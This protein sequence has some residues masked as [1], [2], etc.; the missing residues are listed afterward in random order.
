ME[1][2]RLPRRRAVGLIALALFL[3]SSVLYRTTGWAQSEGEYPVVDVDLTEPDVLIRT[4]SLSSLFRDL[5]RVPLAQD[6]LGEDFVFYYESNPD[7]LGLNGTIR[8]I[9]YEHELTWT[10]RLVSMV[11]DEPADVVLWRGDKGALDHWAIAMTRNSLA[12]LLQE[13]ATAAA[14]DRQLSRFGELTVDGAA[15]TV[16]ALDYAPSQT[17]LIAARGDR[18]VVLSERGLLGDGTGR[19]RV[20]PSLAISQLLSA[21]AGKRRIFDEAFPPVPD[22][23]THS[24]AAKLNFLSFGYQDFFPGVDALRFDFGNGQWSSSLL[25]DG[26]ELP[27]DRLNDRGLWSAVPANAA[28]CAM[29]PVDWSRG[30]DI[31]AAMAAD[32]RTADLWQEL[33]GPAVA[34]WYVGA[35]LHAPLIAAT[36]KNP[37]P[38]LEPFLTSLFDWSVKK[39]AATPAVVPRRAATDETWWQREMEVPFSTV[40]RETGRPEPGDLTITLA[41]KGRQIFFSPSADHVSRALDT[42]AKRYPSMADTLPIGNVSLAVFSPAGLASLGRRESLAMLPRM[43]EPVFRV[44]AEERLLPRLDRIARYP[45]YRLALPTPTASGRRWDTVTWQELPR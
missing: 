9:A 26:A 29:L 6:L 41:V 18:L 34:C 21:D 19:L 30:R 8:R 36:L 10:D 35:P 28:L 32:V 43:D 42:V 4:R 23:L 24:V 13:V 20:D 12:T 37:R 16:Y 40:D 3:L 27:T 45:S 17:L 5:L 2:P 38:A 33:E 25:V 44:A 1:I 31:S 11:F 15:V 22:G 14:K 7:R 39:P